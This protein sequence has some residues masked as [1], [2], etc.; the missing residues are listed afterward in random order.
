MT[1]TYSIECEVCEQE[2][3]VVSSDD[4][5]DTMHCPSCG[6]EVRVALVDGED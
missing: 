6:S 1:S 3:Y 2:F 4:D 5:H